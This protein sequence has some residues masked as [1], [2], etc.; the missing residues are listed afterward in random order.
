MRD[1]VVSTAAFGGAFLWRITPQTNFLTAFAC[2]L[3]GTLWFAVR[4]R[5][6]RS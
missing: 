1:A 4:G 3:L 6:L 2:G 5:D